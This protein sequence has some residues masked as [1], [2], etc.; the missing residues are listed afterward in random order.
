MP[1]YLVPKG[2]LYGDLAETRIQQGRALPLA[3]RRRLAFSTVE[4]YSRSSPDEPVWQR[5]AL[6]SD[7]QV[8]YR[9][10]HDLTSP[11][12][13]ISGLDMNKAHL[14][15]I[16]NVT[17]DSFSDGGDSFETS[18][19]V[20]HARTMVDEG[21]SIVDIGGE[22]TRPGADQVTEKQEMERILPVFEE[23]KGSGFIISVD[24]RNAATMAEA[25]EH[26]VHIINDVSALTHDPKSLTIAVDSA[27]PVIL[28]HA[29]GSP[30][31]MQNNPTYGHVLVDIYDYLERRI[32]EAVSAGI[33]RSRIMIDPGL[34]FGKT[35]EHN[36]AIMSNLALF[37]GLGVPI[38]FGASRKSF[39]GTLSNVQQASRRR[40]GS[41][42]AA[43]AAVSQGAQIIRVHD[44]RQTREALSV[45]NAI[46]D[47]K[48][49]LA[50]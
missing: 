21:A 34:G 27:L 25:A 2:F 12:S 47:P 32:A 9:V 5:N 41:V 22:S 39:I 49:Y 17:P 26:G 46:N 29:Q 33:D 13:P 15:G 30:K 31:D 42:A 7:G 36:V 4:I 35:L 48:S 44:V 1:D 40:F 50:E 38:V 28:M 8:E 16:V 10:P 37:H 14:M 24:T 19:A 23:L 11:R 43:I 3:G 45:W 6:V 20:T 18:D